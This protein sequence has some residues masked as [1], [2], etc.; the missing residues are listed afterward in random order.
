[1][2][3]SIIATIK[4]NLRAINGKA[5]D[6]DLGSIVSVENILANIP[7]IFLLFLMAIL[8]I[9]NTH[10]VEKTV[11]KIN[12]LN[13]ELKEIRWQYMSSKADLMYKSKQTE[14]A[15]SVEALGLKELRNPPKKII[16]SKNE[17]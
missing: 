7:F 4:N 9:G 16:V 11:R 3:N 17:Y 6:F 15:R 2:A 12:K 10:L 5:R 14:V 13:T 1:M 8:Y